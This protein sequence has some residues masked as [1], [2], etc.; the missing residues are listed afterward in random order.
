MSN[1]RPEQLEVTTGASDNDSVTTKGYVDETTDSIDFWNRI[2]GTPNYVIPGISADHL[3]ATAERVVKGWFINLETTNIP[4]IGGDVLNASHVEMSLLG[5]P[6][7]EDVQDFINLSQGASLWSG[8]TISDGSAGTVDIAAGTGLIKTTNSGVGANVS[9]DYAGTTGLALTDNST[10]F[11][12]IDYNSGTP[13]AAAIVAY[14]SLNLRTQIV[15][16]RV[17]RTGSSVNILQVGQYFEEYQTKDCLKSFEVDAFQRA[18]GELLGETGT[19][20]LTVSAG[21]DYCAHNRITTPAI[22]T[23]AADTFDV[24]NSSASVSADTT[25][26]SQ[27][28]NANYWNGAAV[29]ALTPNRY[30]TRFFYR[31]H[32]GEI[33]M[34]YGT[35]NTASPATALAELVP[36]TPSF[37]TN[38]ALYIGRVVIR[39]GAA[40]F[41]DITKPFETPEQGTVVTNHGDLA[42]LAD[43][44]HPQYALL[45]GRSGGQTVIGG[46][47][48][49]DDLILQTTSDGTKGDYRFS[50]LT[51]A[52]GLLRTDGSGNVTSSIDLPDGTTGT[53]QTA[54]DNSTKIATTAY[55][56]G[57]KVS[58][59]G[60]PT[61]TGVTGQWAYG[62][63][64]E[65]RCV[66]TDTWIRKVVGTTW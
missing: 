2:T 51:T 53:T 62:S 44:D 58:V 12:Y 55:I 16:G 46:T 3:G 40:V 52:N 38:F 6:T 14:T 57:Q 8:F 26:V 21:V 37:L 34:Q 54:G 50:E 1:L 41:Y 66:A 5:T 63:G 32:D 59:P 45:A 64:Y 23:S 9:F 20:N 60:T 25:G 24:W 30:T 39:D 4:T 56:D 42:G 36:V 47:A 11:I 29:V 17:Y 22:D 43:D 13:I 33:H 15:V 19:R 10:N 28:D 18:S 61:S 35:S 49:G 48:S 27:V 7:Y 31:A 65:Y